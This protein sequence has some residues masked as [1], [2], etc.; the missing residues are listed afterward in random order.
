MSNLRVTDVREEDPYHEPVQTLRRD[1]G[2]SRYT[3][4]S[5]HR[6]RVEVVTQD[7][8]HPVS[9]IREGDWCP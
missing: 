1:G 6:G 2:R 7:Y 9:R 8:P 4:L 3:E 5:L